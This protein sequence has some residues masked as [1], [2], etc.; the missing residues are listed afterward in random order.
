MIGSLA[1]FMRPIAFCPHLTMSLAFSTHNNL[2]RNI[3]NTNMLQLKRRLTEQTSCLNSHD[4]FYKNNGQDKK[5]E[6]I[7]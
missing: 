7:I 3:I 6:F 2:E 1:I 5:E 4:S